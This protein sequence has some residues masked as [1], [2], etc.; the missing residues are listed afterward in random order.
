MIA[1]Y[2]IGGYLLLG[3]A[4]FVFYL[5]VML[6][7]R[8][9]ANLHGMARVAGYAVF[10]IGWALD[11]A[12]NL[13]SS[14]PFVDLPQELMFTDRVSR[15]KKTTGWRS[16]LAHWFCDNLLEPFDKGHCK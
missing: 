8:E 11:L 10:G 14:I 2:L 4:T 5:A 1:L 12:F 6:L 16:K 3:Y 7:K 9:S 13:A 15:L